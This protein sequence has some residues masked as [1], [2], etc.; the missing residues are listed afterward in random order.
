MN[1]KT[2]FTFNIR[3]ETGTLPELKKKN[4]FFFAYAREIQAQEKKGSSRE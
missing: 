1:L 3:H 2:E 4:V